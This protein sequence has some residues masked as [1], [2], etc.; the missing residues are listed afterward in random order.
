MPAVPESG[1][2]RCVEPKAY[3]NDSRTQ[4]MNWSLMAN[5]AWDYPANTLGFTNGATAELNMRTWTGRLG[6]FTV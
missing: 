3:A 5:D 6:I 2:L 4:F 1:T